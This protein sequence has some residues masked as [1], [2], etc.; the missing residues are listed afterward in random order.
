MKYDF[1]TGFSGSVESISK[2]EGPLGRRAHRNETQR[3]L[4]E[5]EIACLWSDT[6]WAQDWLREEKKFKPTLEDE[7]LLDHS[8]LYWF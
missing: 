4:W 5:R 1:E 6:H 8:I 2:I 7:T 3:R